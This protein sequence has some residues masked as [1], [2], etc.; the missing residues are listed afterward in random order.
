VAAIYL[1]Y[2]VSQADHAQ[3][4]NEG[5]RDGRQ[6]MPWQVAPE[7]AQPQ[8]NSMLEGELGWDQGKQYDDAGEFPGN[9]FPPV[10]VERATL[11]VH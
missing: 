7:R 8:R 2:K 6:Q 9:R 1:I 4:V 5:V 3:H 10:E 11:R